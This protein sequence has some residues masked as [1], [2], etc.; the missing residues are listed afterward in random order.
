MQTESN[1]P[2]TVSKAM[3]LQIEHIIDRTRRCINELSASDDFQAETNDLL[4]AHI[5]A[6]A[7][8]VVQG[9][10]NDCVDMSS[11]MLSHTSFLR[12]DGR[13][14]LLASLPSDYLRLE[15]L[16]VIKYGVNGGHDT[17]SPDVSGDSDGDIGGGS[18]SEATD[19]EVT[20][21][22][23]VEHLVRPIHTI[24]PAGHP[25]YDEQWSVVCGIGAGSYR[26][27]AYRI[28]G[29]VEIH[30]LDPLQDPVEA[31]VRLRYV[32]IPSVTTDVQG[33]EC[34][35]TLHDI[36]LDAV[37]WRAAAL[38]LSMTGQE[39]ASA[40]AEVSNSLMASLTPTLQADDKS[41]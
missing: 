2:T 41:R 39:S 8:M 29:D 19:G 18:G 31:G 26:P 38:Y 32:A 3:S 11:A 1:S 24:L 33:H 40:A 36:L 5:Q 25:S 14:Y 27:A 20:A 7:R 17:V 30:S 23:L 13:R 16:A 21:T 22:G 12:P 4:K 6:A 35:A 10:S 15:E 37:S 9:V 34:F 28:D